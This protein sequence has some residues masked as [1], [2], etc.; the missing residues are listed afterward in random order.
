MFLKLMVY[1]EGNCN[2]FF[3]NWSDTAESSNLTVSHCE[4][5]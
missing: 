2:D 5:W 3:T 4:G 1:F